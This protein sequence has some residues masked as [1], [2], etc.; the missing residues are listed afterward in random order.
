VISG[1]L[2]E[3]A[4]RATSY[5][6]RLRSAA[7]TASPIIR[8]PTSLNQEQLIYSTLVV[9]LQCGGL[10]VA[11]A[12]VFVQFTDPVI[13]ADGRI[14]H[15][16]VCGGEMPDGLWQGWIEFEPAAGGIVLRSGRETTQP[17]REDAIYWATGLTA[18][19]LEGALERALKPLVRT[20]REPVEVRPT[21]DRPADDFAAPPAAESILNPFSVYRKGEALLRSQLSA[22]S[23]WHLVNIIRAHDLSDLDPAVL[24]TMQAP[25]LV[26]LI[27]SSVRS[28]MLSPE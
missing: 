5:E 11:V 19:Y 16:R 9:F 1:P 22:L 15:A 2:L 25:V 20:P 3:E 21:Y 6:Q 18:V 12:E 24:D 8:S 27:V 13:A 14:Y 7:A 23:A 4:F 10:E 17:K 26:E 28:L